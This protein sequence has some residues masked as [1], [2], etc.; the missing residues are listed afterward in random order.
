MQE[1]GL[2]LILWV[3]RARN[4]PSYD[5]VPLNISQTINKRIIT[6]D[7][8]WLLSLLPNPARSSWSLKS[9]LFYRCSPSTRSRNWTEWLLSWSG[10]TCRLP[11]SKFWLFTLTPSLIRRDIAISAR[12]STITPFLRIGGYLIL[13][14]SRRPRSKWGLQSLATSHSPGSFVH[15]TINCP[16]RCR[17]MLCISI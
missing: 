11:S 6:I 3:A 17:T 1:I 14:D 8:I 10:W 2:L 5:F 7:I 13:R 15:K 9:R 4:S 16:R 12:A